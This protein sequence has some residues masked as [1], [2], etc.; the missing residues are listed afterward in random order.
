MISGTELVDILFLIPLLLELLQPLINP[1]TTPTTTTSTT[2][3]TTTTTTHPRY[4]CTLNFKRKNNFKFEDFHFITN[5]TKN[6][7]DFL[8]TGLD[9]GFHLYTGLT[10]ILSL[11]V[12][13]LNSNILIY[14]LNF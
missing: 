4:T 1:P 9:L 8:D 3:T 7:R 2:S 6:I 5:Y 13:N 10:L 14:S 12:I 11:Q